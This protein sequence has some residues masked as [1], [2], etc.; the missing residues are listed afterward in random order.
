MF[1]VGSVAIMVIISFLVSV[2]VVEIG[3]GAEVYSS[4][5]GNQVHVRWW[6]HE[7][8]ELYF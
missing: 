2:V 5:L 4:I 6:R 3:Y 8:I 7:A 1:F